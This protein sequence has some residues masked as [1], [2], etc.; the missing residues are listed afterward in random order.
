MRTAVIDLG[1][2]SARIAIFERTSRLSFYILGEYK[3]RVRLGEGAYENGGVIQKEAMQNCY[4]AFLEFKK[5]IKSYKVSKV[6]CY[7]TSALRDAP[8]ANEFINLI[9]KNLG[10]N[11][12]CIDGRTEAYLGG[13]AAANL[14]SGFEEGTTIDIG[15]GSTELA[16]IEQGKITDA[17]SLNLGTVRLKELFFD[18]NN[19][20]GIDDF[21]EQ[22][23]QKIGANFYSQNVISI[24][25]SL[26]AIANSIMIKKNHPLKIVHNFDYNFDENLPFI[27]NIIDSNQANLKNFYIKK[28]RFDTIREG[29]MI[30]AKVAKKIGARQIFTSGVGIR[31]GA[32]LFNILRG[33]N[34]L[35]KSVEILEKKTFPKGYNPSLD[36]LQKRFC[37][38]TKSQVAKISN[39]I[40]F[41]L[42]N[43]HKID[44]KFLPCL[45][46][47]AKLSEIGAKLGFYSL[48][49]HSAYFVENGLNYGHTHQQKALIS[50]ILR[51]KNKDEIANSNLKSLLPDDKIIFWL[52]FILEISKILNTANYQD[53]SF[54]YENLTLQIG[55]IKNEIIIKEKIKKLNKPEIFAI[56]FI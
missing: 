17:I 2:N 15:G 14:I 12:K 4:L 53:L 6:L 33:K 10:L 7:G 18:K 45:I 1:S 16:R 48:H 56:G 19:F 41:T 47:A 35:A 50:T 42:R 5:I 46:D 52:S 9:K 21:F 34:S 3:M 22:N 24:G 25:G 37:T 13:I 51:T 8:N 43:L 32:F 38:K 40:F 55:G 26:R 29:A 28:D 54:N 31:E 23:L 11:L 39:K 44:D 36:S 49:E 30:F 27:E 20:N